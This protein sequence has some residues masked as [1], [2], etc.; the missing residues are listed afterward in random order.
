ME[1]R[2]QLPRL[3]HVDLIEAA[4]DL[5]VATGA[6][7]LRAKVTEFIHAAEAANT[8]RAYGSAWRSFRA[9]CDAHH[10]ASLPASPSVVGAYVADRASTLKP[11]T[12]AVHLAAIRQAH[13]LAGTASPGRSLE[14]GIVMKGIRRS[15]DIAPS[16]KNAL[17][18]GDLRVV[19]E[20]LRGDAV[21]HRD[22]ALL[23]IGFCAGL[24]RSELVGLDIGDL[25]FEGE[26]LVITIRRSKTDQE[27]RGR[28]I[29]LGYGNAEGTCPVTAARRWLAV[30]NETQGP[31][32]RP[33]DRHGRVRRG[34]LSDRGVARLVQRLGAHVGLDPR[35]LGG[36]SL[37]SG[38]A[39]SAAAAGVEERQIA[40]TTG[41]R[42]VVTLRSYV[43]AATV[44]EGDVVRRLGL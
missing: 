26:G 8:R 37:R 20:R 11:S 38:F 42:S 9:W 16:K 30:L 17:R 31:V 2:R 41:H 4:A 5:S 13:A 23:L 25:V 32:F 1:R 24:R 34:R 40:R 22:R 27:G 3:E 7:A 36:H 14:V 18:V 21:G 39:T 6:A 43:Q 35:K 44:F 10:V 12:L 15:R 29:G 19:L 28:R 33:V